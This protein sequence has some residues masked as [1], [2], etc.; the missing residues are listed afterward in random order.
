MQW[1][2]DV[3]DDVLHLFR[4][5]VL[6]T[7][8]ETIV[9]G[10]WEAMGDGHYAKALTEGARLVVSAPPHDDAAAV[11]RFSLFEDAGSDSGRTSLAQSVSG[12]VRRLNL[13]NSTGKI[14]ATV[15]AGDLAFNV[16]LT[17]Q[18]LRDGRLFPGQSLDAGYRIDQITWI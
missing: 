5:Q 7:R 2:H 6:G 10:P 4:G 11:I 12:I 8:H 14:I 9:F 3:C 13:E 17:E 18:Q 1:L 15:V 16:A